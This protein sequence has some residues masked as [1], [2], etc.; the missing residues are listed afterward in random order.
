MKK[1][2]KILT[3]KCKKAYHY[4]QEH[5]TAIF[6][7]IIL[8]LSFFLK[9]SALFHD[10]TVSRDGCYYLFLATQWYEKGSWE[11]VLSISCNLQP[12]LLFYAIKC[13][14]QLGFSAEVAGFSI[15]VFLGALTPLF[16][17]AIAKEITNDQTVSLFSAFI[18]AI[19]P[20]VNAF[21]IEIQRDAAYLFW[22]GAII[23]MLILGIKRRRVSYWILGGVFLGFSILTRYESVEFFAIVP[24]CLFVL[25]I[26]KYFSWKEAL[27]FGGIYF[28][29]CIGCIVFLG[30]I[31][32]IQKDIVY[33][34]KDYFL[35]KE[36]MLERSF[37][38]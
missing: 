17:Y 34:Y 24:I 7:T 12:P 35:D 11:S 28:S 15:S 2:E 1:K 19:N 9:I 32:G 30:F 38:N 21:S 6:L 22:V 4:C 25:S 18:F 14:M 36:K 37:P 29:F 8:L 33:N 23:W 10:S 5:R 31:M 26:K 13:M 16:A 27:V 3:K 20:S